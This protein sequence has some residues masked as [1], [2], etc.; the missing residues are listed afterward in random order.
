MFP[1]FR[2]RITR[3]VGT[4]LALALAV[5]FYDEIV[6]GVSR[7]ATPLIR[8]D[9]NLNYDQIGLLFGI[10]TVLATIIEPF[11]GIAGDTKRRALL[12]IGGTG[13]YALAM[14]L[15][16][17]SWAF[18]PLLIAQC[19]YFPGA[20]ASMGLTQASL[21]DADPARRENNM[22]RWAL[23]GSLGN[24]AGPIVM[25]VAVWLLGNNES[26]AW[27]V[28]YLLLGVM[29]FGLML[30]TYRMR[31]FYHIEDAPGQIDLLA[32][33]REALR[34]LRRWVVVRWILLLDVADLLMDIFRAYMALYFI[35]VVGLDETGASVAL[36]VFTAVG[37]MGDIIII[38]VLER[39]RG[40]VYLRWSAAFAGVIYVIFLLTPSIPLKFVLL[41]V[42]GISNAG[43]YAILQAQ[44]YA[45]V[46]KRSGTVMALNSIAGFASGLLPAII[47]FIA[48]RVGLGA[49]MWLLLLAPIALFIGIPRNAVEVEIDDED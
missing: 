40:L 49:A 44:L 48:G 20:G 37:L 39:V 41:G 43:W 1:S 9:L 46:P 24:L 22:A 30:W 8:D 21:M 4:F 5:E 47:G 23:A 3:R 2:S 16:G 36:I 27:R 18:I 38:P 10:P 33:V 28:V 25:L 14:A 35:D 45:A 11:I 31:H 7:V 15:T 19:L 26:L 42:L 13:I 12:V 29:G 34:E 32:G 6:D 17:I